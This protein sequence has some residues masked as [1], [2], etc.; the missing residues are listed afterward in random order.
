MGFV[1][2]VFWV[3]C[4]L[5]V[6]LPNWEFEQKEYALV[7]EPKTVLLCDIAR[8][9]QKDIAFE[10]DRSDK[11]GKLLAMILL[12]G[13]QGNRYFFINLSSYMNQCWVILFLAILNQMGMKFSW[14]LR[15]EY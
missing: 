5:F 6:K 14:V 15:K 13:G 2:F 9:W 12:K 8:S 1:R 3:I 4:Q 7:I 11:A 10:F